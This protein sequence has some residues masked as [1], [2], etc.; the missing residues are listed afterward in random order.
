MSQSQRVVALTLLCVACGKSVEERRVDVELC[1]VSSTEAAAISTC[2]REQ[3][4]WRAAAA[5]SAGLAR[6]HEL[7][8]VRTEIGA[9]TAR[10]DSQHLAEMQ[11]CDHLLEDFRTCLLTRY[12]W[13]EDQATRTDDSLWASRSAEHQRQIRACLGPRAIGTGACLQLHYKWSP[14]R[15][16]A[17]DDSIR[18]ANLP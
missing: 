5:E 16:L 9:L 7:D 1:S 8:S 11:A 12:G 6:A 17:L 3:N 4:G 18:R 13:Q 14:R 10:A 2:L 15:A